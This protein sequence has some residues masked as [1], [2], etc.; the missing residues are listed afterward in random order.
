[1]HWWLKNSR[2]VATQIIVGHKRLVSQRQMP[3]RD[4]EPLH[5]VTADI[6]CLENGSIQSF[7]KARAYLIS[8]DMC[9]VFPSMYV[10]LVQVRVLH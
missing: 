6:S 1:M 10:E 7:R 8:R 2:H 3:E 9:V 4:F 5:F